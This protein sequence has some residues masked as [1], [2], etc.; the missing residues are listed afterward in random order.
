MDVYR[1][2]E[3]E[4]NPIIEPHKR[5]SYYTE[6]K[7]DC[8]FFDA[9]AEAD[10]AEMG[11]TMSMEHHSGVT[12]LPKGASSSSSNSKKIRRPGGYSL[13][14]S[15][16]NCD[17]EVISEAAIH[18]KVHCQLV[19]VFGAGCDVHELLADRPTTVR[20]Q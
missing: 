9:F 16:W 14:S 7:S 1:V 10:R 11:D 12:S 6:K 5:K 19:T 15:V 2:R 8:D 18:V 3:F 17:G 13:S 20:F 4:F